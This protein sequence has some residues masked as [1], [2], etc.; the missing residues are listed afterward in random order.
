MFYANGDY[1]QVSGS[2]VKD[3]RLFI[4]C[5]NNDG[6]LLLVTTDELEQLFR[7]AFVPF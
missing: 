3:Q 5:K 2:V 1:W 6:N 4:E 7:N